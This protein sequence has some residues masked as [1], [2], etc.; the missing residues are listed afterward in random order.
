MEQNHVIVALCIGTLAACSIAMCG[1]RTRSR[2]V[3]DPPRVELPS[4]RRP[5][6]DK[7]LSRPL[8]CFSRRLGK[9]RQT[10]IAVGNKPHRY[11]NS[12]AI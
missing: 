12:H 5:R 4:S 9:A 8:F 2:T 6:G 10:D 1:L 11:G 3:V 7:L